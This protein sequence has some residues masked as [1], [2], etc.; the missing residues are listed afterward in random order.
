MSPITDTL[1]TYLPNKR[2]QTPSGWISFNAVCCADKR[3]RGGLIMSGDS[4]SYH[5]FNC[6]FKASWQPGRTISQ[7]LRKLFEL[8]HVPDDIISKLCIEALRHYDSIDKPMLSIPKFEPRSL[9][10]GSVLIKDLIHD[11]PEQLIPILEYIQSRCL[12]LEDYDFYWTPEEGFN[13]RLI[14]PYFYKGIIV[15]YTARHIDQ[16]KPKYLAEQQ[17]GYVFN[18][19][20]QHENRKYVI[21]CE[22][23]L[24]AISIDAVSVNGSEIS[25]T[26]RLLIN[27]LQRE[28]IVVPD[29]DPAGAK[30]IKTALNY[31]WNVSF[32]TWDSSIKD[33]ND[34]IKYYGKINTLL[35]IID[36][37]YSSETKIKLK[38]KEWLKSLEQ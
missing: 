36:S 37:V 20:N 2:K 26:Q 31:N 35:M 3:N 32:P 17:P 25:E 15:G 23:Q 5:C 19:D 28:V 9:P 12:T 34:S 1:Q 38:E 4:V 30:L 22:G 10:R 33:I 16:S 8:L 21:V 18:L 29:Q 27:Q 14:I 11:P 24:D 6:G 13:N 7:K